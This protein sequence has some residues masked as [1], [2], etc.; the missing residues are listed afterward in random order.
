[1]KSIN[2][3]IIL[4]GTTL[5][6]WLLPKSYHLVTDKASPNIFT[7]YSSVDKAF[8]TIEFNDKEER[9]IRS[10]IKTKKEYNEYEFDSILPMFYSRQLFADGR[11]PESIQGL[12]MKPRE[13]NSKKF[14]FRM[15][16]MGKNK[17]H[18]PLYTLFES[19]SKRVRIEMPG[20][21]FRL[22]SKIEFIN[23]ET[24]EV[25]REKSDRFN[26]VLVKR[27]FEFPAKQ[28]AGNP[29]TRK[30][31]DEGYLIIDNADQ[32]FHLKMVN[33]MPF[34]KKVKLPE[35]LVPT[36]L[37]TMEPD[38]RSF[39]AFV[40]DSKKRLHVLSTDHYKLQEV[41][42]PAYDINKDQLLIMANPLYW[43]VN[44]INADAKTVLAI[45]A[46][47]KEKVDEVVISHDSAEENYAKFVLPFSV[48]F[49]H[50]NTRF[51]KPVVYFGS[52][53]VLMLN[54]FF[55]ALFVFIMKIRKQ[56]LQVIPLLWI[57]ITGIYGLI[58]SLIFNK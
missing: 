51:I 46:D 7:Y 57:S 26:K 10:N 55:A 22:D 44:V 40:Y 11:M 19:M 39:Y 28:I 17:P 1:M 3:L 5:L 30:A 34:V 54:V 47:S 37:M 6:A 15:N 21:F 29:S 49:T 8:C 20:D 45:R 16:P 38:D 36:Y 27:G 14:F 35:G 25:N 41:P 31:Y 4:L 58:A 52:V 9:L 32:I 12:D 24:N 18:V 2:Y 48:G 13:I 23:P 50:S 43:N 42:T 53:W 33:N 56:K